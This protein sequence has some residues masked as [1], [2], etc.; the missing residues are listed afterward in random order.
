MDKGRQ[1]A[2]STA[3]SF[4]LDFNKVGVCKHTAKSH[5]PSQTKGSC[6][7]DVNGSPAQPS[8]TVAEQPEA[9][10]AGAPLS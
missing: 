4:Q 8:H 1:Q 9:M 7:S 6:V 10:A 5:S 3:L 2:K